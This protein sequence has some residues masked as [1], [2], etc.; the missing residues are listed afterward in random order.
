LTHR[1]VV[2]IDQT[3]KMLNTPDWPYGFYGYNL[4]NAG[5]LFANGVPPRVAE[6]SA[7]GLA[8]LAERLGGPPAF[9]DPAAAETIRLLL[10]YALQDWGD[11]VSR[12]DRPVLMVARWR[13]ARACATRTLASIAALVVRVL[14]M[15]NELAKIRA[16]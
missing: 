15:R 6:K 9:R 4:A 12:I 13:E 5:I 2:I 7:P 8:R 14:A 16:C 11:V 1:D 3:P 10:D